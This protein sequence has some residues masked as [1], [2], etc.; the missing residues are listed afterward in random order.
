MGCAPRVQSEYGLLLRHPKDSPSAKPRRPLFGGQIRVARHQGST[1][2]EHISE[3]ATIRSSGFPPRNRPNSIRRPWAFP[4]T[5]PENAANFC[6]DRRFGGISEIVRGRTSHTQTSE[7]S[8][9]RR[10]RRSAIAQ[11][12]LRHLDFT[13]TTLVG[14]NQRRVG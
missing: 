6:V 13:S 10:T 7:Q 12:Y 1:R 5:T 14:G 4:V 2:T 3:M 8:S 9:G 11:D